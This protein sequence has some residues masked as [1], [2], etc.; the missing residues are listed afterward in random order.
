MAEDP[1]IIPTEGESKGG[2]YRDVVTGRVSEQEDI[3]AGGA[4]DEGPRITSL[5]AQNP[6]AFLSAGGGT[7]KI[8]INGAKGSKFSLEIKDSNGN[9]ILEE[10]LNDVEIP[11]SGIYILN[12][13]FPSIATTST[14]R[15]DDSVVKE[16]YE[17]FITPHADVET[18]ID[19]GIPIHTFHQYRN[20]KIT[21]TPVTTQTSP[22]IVMSTGSISRKNKA[23]ILGDDIPNHTSETYTITCTENTPTAGFFYVK[24]ASFNKNITT[25]S[26]IK[27]IVDRC[28]E[29][30]CTNQ[31]VLNPS[32]TRTRVV[33][34]ESIISS[35]IEVGMIAYYKI[36]KQKIVTKSID[37]L[38]STKS[39]KKATNRFQLNNTTD[40]F[41]N[42]KM[43]VEGYGPTHIVSIDCD[44][45]ITVSGKV[46]IKENADVTFSYEDRSIVSEITNQNTSKGQTTLKLTRCIDIPD[47][48]EL[49]FDDNDSK[50][51]GTM[52]FTG[53]GSKSVSLKGFI[54]FF[55]Y[56]TSNVVYNLDL[57][58]M[59]TR[60]PNAFDQNIVC[61]KNSAVSIDTTKRDFDDN[62]TSKTPTITST[63]RHGSATISSRSIRYVPHKSFVGDDEI[64]FTISDGTNVSNEKA[65]RI[66][67]E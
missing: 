45:E 36:E 23:G 20:T 18:Y 6:R 7:K 41:L 5:Q 55:K 46:I 28:G 31:L 62:L 47:N 9:D 65:I 38:D 3:A 61:S 59:I 33:N 50:I 40:L 29:E 14:F 30:G 63:S 56:G 17:V 32:T 39:T 43:T 42:M 2:M 10:A 34:S 48:T 19:P 64:K 54:S 25:N 4:G 11:N 1:T 67:V 66:T 16:T 52:S 26:I 35:D 58:N 51:H 13:K 44:R 21:I 53:S 37:I 60:T 12:Q 57:D 8:S 15:D 24:N 49:N 22:S 27:K